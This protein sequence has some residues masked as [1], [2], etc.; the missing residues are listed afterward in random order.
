MYIP[1]GLPPAWVTVAPNTVATVRVS[2][3]VNGRKSNLLGGKA[4]V[5]VGAHGSTYRIVV[6]H[7][8]AILVPFSVVHVEVV[9]RHRTR[10]PLVSNQLHLADH[11]FSI[12]EPNDPSPV[13]EWQPVAF[14]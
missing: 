7:S 1:M 6:A 11:A 3:F 2:V 14:A 9:H 13:F 5:R 12:C 10:K 8:Q 4:V